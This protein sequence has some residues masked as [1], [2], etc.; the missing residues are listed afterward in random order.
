MCTSEEQV[1]SGKITRGNKTNEISIVREKANE[2]IFRKMLKKSTFLL[3]DCLLNYL[4][5]M[6]SLNKVDCL[7]FFYLILPLNFS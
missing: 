2:I 3:F 4:I 6:M 5:F 7:L 1:A